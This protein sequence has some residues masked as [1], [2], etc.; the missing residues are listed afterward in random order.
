M[1]ELEK[2]TLRFQGFEIL[3]EVNVYFT[4]LPN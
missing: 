3:I 1:M 2:V 4:E